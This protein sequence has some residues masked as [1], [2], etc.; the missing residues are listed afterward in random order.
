MR[1][2][3]TIL[4]V[5]TAVMVGFA[6]TVPPEAANSPRSVVSIMP[7]VGTNQDRSEKL[8]KQYICR[9]HVRVVTHKPGGRMVREETADYESVPTPT[10]ER[11]DLKLIT[12]RFWEKGK[13]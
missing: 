8:R 10:G 5:V 4:F 6:Q 13:Y 7:R 9:E 3:S 11:T 2:I 1:C 12:G